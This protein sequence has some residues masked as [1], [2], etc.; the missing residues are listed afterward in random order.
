MNTPP[1]TIIRKNQYFRFI[2][3]MMHMIFII[4][5]IYYLINES[6]ILIFPSNSDQKVYT[7]IAGNSWH[8]TNNLK[9]SWHD[10]E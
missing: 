8:D 9:T 5:H 2:Q 7:I 3:L 4:G 1:V 10:T 6:K